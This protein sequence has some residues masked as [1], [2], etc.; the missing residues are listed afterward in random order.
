MKLLY[1]S[2]ILST[3]TFG[4]SSD[5]LQGVPQYKY[6]EYNII[7][8]KFTVKFSKIMSIIC[9]FY[10]G[11]DLGEFYYVFYVIS[12]VLLVFILYNTL[13]LVPGVTKTRRC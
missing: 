8:I 1:I 10:N 4:H 6:K 11:Q 3:Y 12:V 2:F 13:K 7:H 9:C 5:S